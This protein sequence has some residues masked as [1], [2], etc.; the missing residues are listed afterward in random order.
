MPI[1]SFLKKCCFLLRVVGEGCDSTFNSWKTNETWQSSSSKELGWNSV[2]KYCT[3]LVDT[4]VVCTRSLLQSLTKEIDCQYGNP[5]KISG[6]FLLYLESIH[7]SASGKQIKCRLSNLLLP[8]WGNTQDL[9]PLNDL[10][11][12]LVC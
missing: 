6:Q 4:T 2:S 9:I 11:F 12:L 5:L 3:S 10:L 7:C 8:V 1:C